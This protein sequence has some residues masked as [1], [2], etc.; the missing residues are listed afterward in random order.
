MTA[1]C[2]HE[3]DGMICVPRCKEWEDNQPVTI[4]AGVF[5]RLRDLIID[6]A[7][8]EVERKKRDAHPPRCP[9]T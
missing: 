4:S 2:K 1:Y 9:A 6:Y 5:N 3:V 7:T 8:D